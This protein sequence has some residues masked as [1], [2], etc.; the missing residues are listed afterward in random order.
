MG[1]GVI[2]RIN[3]FYLRA[4]GIVGILGGLT[5]FAGDMLFYYDSLSTNLLLNMSKASDSRI[6]A[7]GVLALLATWLYLLG[8]IPVFYAF[9]PAKKKNRYSVVI[10]F[11]AILTS[12]G[13]IHGAYIAIATS[14]KLA[15]ENQLNVEEATS[16]ALAANQAI[17]LIIYPVFAFLSFLFIREVWKKNTLYPRWMLFFFP[18]LPFLLENLITGALSG[19]AWV[20]VEGGYL[21]LILVLFFTAST[22]ALWNH[23]NTEDVEA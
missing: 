4:L 1:V 8:L 13:I 17:R 3:K 6:A 5:L 7:N 23:A 16:L 11:A 22:A 19:R 10:A 12:Y 9:S 2:M 21:N 14:A 18:L 15:A 20:I